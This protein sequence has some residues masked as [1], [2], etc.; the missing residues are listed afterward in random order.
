[1]RNSSLRTMFRSP[2]VLVVLVVLLWF[3]ATFL[4]FPNINLLVSTFFPGGEFSARAVEKLFSSERA[5]KSLFNSFLLAISLAVTVNVVGIFIVL[6]TKYFQIRGSRVLWLGYA[7]TLIYGGI[8]L[9][10]G[11]NFIYGRYGFITNAVRNVWPEVDP[12]WFSGFFAVLLVMTFATTTNHMLFL[13]SSLA[14]IDYQTIEAAR[15]MGAST[16]KILW[17]IV[18]PALRPMIFAVTV[19][20]F[21]TGLGALTAPLVIGGADFQTI[22]PM[23][24]TFS[25]SASSRDLAALLAIILGLA[26][27][28]LLA[29]MNRVEK[30]GVYFSVAKVAT[31]LKKQRIQN[32]AANVVVHVVAYLLFIVYAT[33]V[34]LIVLFSFVDSTAVLTGSIT[35]SSFTLDNYATVFGSPAVLRPF[36]VSI[37]YSALAALIVVGGLLFVARVIQKYRNPVTSVLEYLLHIPWILPTILIALALVMT[38]DRPNPLIGGQVLTGTTVLLLV[39]YII[40]KIPFTLRLLKAAFA[41]IPDSLEDAARI[42]GAK[43]LFTFRRVLF[44]LVIPTAAAITALNFNSLLDDYDAAVFLYHPLYEPLGIAIKASTEGESN[45]DSMSIT[46]VYTVLL[47]IIMGLTMYLVYG[48][49]GGTTRRRKGRNVTPDAVANDPAAA[50]AVANT[51]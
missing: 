35:L 17:K 50:A 36:I 49:S 47:M 4:L 12:N 13:S 31:P 22:A 38:F 9:A 3:I 25:K 23:I 30:S 5:M 39:A 15:N 45:L 41:S 42:L 8:V 43:S 20:T 16:W 48:R 14:K 11:Y 21:L 6:V 34:L 1:M 19:L 27:I 24:V 44:P 18:L 2:L 37:V 10:A 7:T 28:I 32:R 46:F 40:V 33:P 29:V 51:K 26:T